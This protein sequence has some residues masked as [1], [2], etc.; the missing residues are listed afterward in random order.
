MAT[1]RCQQGMNQQ[2]CSKNGGEIKAKWLEIQMELTKR[3]EKW[4]NMGILFQNA[5]KIVEIWDF[6]QKNDDYCR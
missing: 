2:K 6:T 1:H 3:V 4:W 5:V